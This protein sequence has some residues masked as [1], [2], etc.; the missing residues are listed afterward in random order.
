MRVQAAVLDE[1]QALR[2]GETRT[3]PWDELRPNFPG[4]TEKHR[5]EAMVAWLRSQNLSYV[6]NAG[7]LKVRPDGTFAAVTLMVRRDTPTG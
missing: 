5:W 7:D 1:L 2:I 4:V 3:L 6:S